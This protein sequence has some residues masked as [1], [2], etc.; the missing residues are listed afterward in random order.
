ME[1]INTMTMKTIYKITAAAAC[2]LAAWSCAQKTDPATIDTST[3]ISLS[4]GIELFNADGK[5]ESGKDAYEAIVTIVRGSDFE[6]SDWEFEV[7]DPKGCATVERAD[8]TEQFL[9]SF[10]GD[11]C[12]VVKPGLRVTVE[13]N[14]EYR[15]SFDVI[16]TADDGTA[17]TFTFTQLGEKADASVTSDTENIEFMAE[18]GDVT[19]LY[20]SNMGDVFSYSVDYGDGS[21][22]WIEITSDDN[23]GSV[24]LHA[25]EWTDK[26]NPR[27]AVF[28]ITVGSEETSAASLEIPVTQLAADEYYFMFGASVFG[29][30]AESSFQMEK[31]ETGIY[32]IDQYFTYA[33]EGNEILFTKNSRTVSYPYYALSADGTVTEISS[34]AVEIPEGPEIDIDGM[35]ALTVDFNAMTWEW[36]RITNALSM[37][38]E[39]VAGYPTKDYVTSDGSYKTWMTVSLHWNGGDDLSP[40]KL[41]SGLV[42]GHQ[43][44]GYGNTGDA[45]LTDRN[46]EYDTEE[47]GGS[48]KEVLDGSGRPLSETKGR[49]YSGYEAITC[50]P[51][52]CLAYYDLHEFLTEEFVDA[53]GNTIPVPEGDQ[54]TKGT[55]A[56]LSDE[57]AEELY[58][59]ISAQI[60][61][62]CPYGWHIANLQDWKDLFYAAYKAAEGGDYPI[63]ES[64][65]HYSAFTSALTNVGAIMYDEDFGN[66]RTSGFTI[67]ERAEAF[68]F[69]IFCQ[70]W[71]LRR[72]GYDYGPGDNDPRF[73][74]II[75]M[76]GQYTASKKAAWRVY[77][78]G[79][80][81]ITVD[82]GFDFGNGC[83]AAIRC[84]KNYKK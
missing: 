31:V 6:A 37:P 80:G 33:G 9:G 11:D 57:A 74:A 62:I 45:Y 26:L 18:G 43:T 63:D 58:P 71:R 41:G 72:T 25:S 20:E 51:T 27:T 60:L 65:T 47:N 64:A 24:T 67:S 1:L 53:V 13:P 34:E 44:G 28:T 52:G 50:Q 23:A 4:K 42:A 5:T 22:G 15:R 29:T 8:I 12:D 61:G 78:T 30:P 81:S 70:G 21:S 16:I 48:V 59:Q 73:Y 79:N 82:D 10:P 76:R 66:Y 49:L 32:S 83:G 54:I 77:T 19:V 36:E 39:L 14:T 84:V 68:G 40:Y 35:R 7:T 56:A 38:D 2:A 3:R 17:K 55:I 75:P 69:N 46:P